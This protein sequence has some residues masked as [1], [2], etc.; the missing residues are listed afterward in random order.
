MKNRILSLT[1]ALVLCL[2]LTVPVLAAGQTFSDVPRSYWAFQEI[3]AAVEADITN[4]YADGT[5][6]PT[7]SVTNAYFAAFLARAF[8]KGEY[9][10]GAIPGIS[11]T[12]TY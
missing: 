8:Y 12:R 11:L 10:E 7:A 3:N 5:F 9:V 4:G 1:L 6:K 2:G